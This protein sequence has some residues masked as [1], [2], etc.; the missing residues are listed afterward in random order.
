MTVCTLDGLVSRAH[1]TEEKVRLQVI[2]TV[3]DMATQHFQNIPEKVHLT[4]C[5]Y[6]YLHT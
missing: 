6:M 2:Q 1:D 5:M 4:C 3:S